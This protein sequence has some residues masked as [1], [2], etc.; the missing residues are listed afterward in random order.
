MYLVHQNILFDWHTTTN[1]FKGSNY[2]HYLYIWL[3]LKQNTKPES[4]SITTNQ[5]KEAN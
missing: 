2:N 4:Y 3:K 1:N 5:Q